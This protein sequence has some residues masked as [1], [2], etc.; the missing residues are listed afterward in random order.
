MTKSVLVLFLLLCSVHV[1]GHVL[2]EEYYSE[3]TLRFQTQGHTSSIKDVDFVAAKNR[4]VTAGDDKTIQIWQWEPRERLHVIRPL[5]GAGRVGI[6]EA[7]ALSPTEDHVAA[8]G[9]TVA[10]GR[11]EQVLIYET[12]T[13]KFVRSLAG[14]PSRV[15]ALAYS[16]DG[17]FLIAGLEEEGGLKIWQ[18]SDWEELSVE[19]NDAI[20]REISGIDVNGNL[21][22][23]SS[24]DGFV[25][26]YK[27]SPS[28]LTLHARR[29]LTSIIGPN[30]VSISP[31][32]ELVAVGVD[33]REAQS[34]R[35]RVESSFHVLSADDLSTVFEEDFARFGAERVQTVAWT[36]EDE[37]VCLGGWLLA[38]KNN[39]KIGI[40]CW[41]PGDNWAGKNTYVG[42][43]SVLDLYTLPDGRLF[44]VGGRGLQAVFDEM[45]GIDV[46]D[47]V[48]SPDWF[49]PGIDLEATADGRI[50][51]FYNQT[52]FT[53]DLSKRRIS[54]FEPEGHN[55]VKPIRPHQSDKWTFEDGWNQVRNPKI[56]GKTI[57]RG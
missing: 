28:G 19:E 22:A 10:D 40:R 37:A 35:R 18:T 23:V 29:L 41:F 17:D 25:R 6:I 42:L 21:V 11:D 39:E 31:N 27:I 49:T 7:V 44:A 32:G 1:P 55:F 3:P 54:L 9:H 48:Q 2:A 20:S 52:A 56:N 30:A 4:Y 33:D 16:E 5:V 34:A 47:R 51:K 24:H 45:T 12:R 15:S 13:Q 8:G 26:L 14:L 46:L 50:I 53:F 43:E 36:A 38:R 57:R